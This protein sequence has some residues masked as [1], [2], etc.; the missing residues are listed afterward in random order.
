MT[1]F[2]VARN[3]G[4]RNNFPLHVPGFRSSIVN[5][6]DTTEELTEPPNHDV[7][8][9]GEILLEARLTS[10]GNEQS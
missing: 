8:S 4:I 1:V 3:E 2:L 5:E 9:S 7:M 6:F 10:T